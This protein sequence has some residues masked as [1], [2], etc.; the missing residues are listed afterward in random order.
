MPPVSLRRGCC[1]NCAALWIEFLGESGWHIMASFRKALME[2]GRFEIAKAI[3]E[4]LKLCRWE[5]SN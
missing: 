3:V 1:T 2:Q 5:F 4:H